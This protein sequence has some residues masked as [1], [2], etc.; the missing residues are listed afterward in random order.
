MLFGLAGENLSYAYF[1]NP[2]QSSYLLLFTLYECACWDGRLHGKNMRK[3]EEGKENS[4]KSE[5]KV[6][7]ITYHFKFLKMLFPSHLSS[8]KQK[9]RE[10]LAFP[11]PPKDGME[12]ENCFCPT[13]SFHFPALTNIT[14]VFDFDA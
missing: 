8:I 2:R 10:R 3:N 6:L 14:Y 11:F 4:S 9:M 13:I 5:C 12:V 1:N 7:K